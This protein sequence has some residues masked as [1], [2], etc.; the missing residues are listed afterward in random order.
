VTSRDDWQIAFELA[1]TALDLSVSERKIWLANIAPEYTHLRSLLRD[2]LDAETNQSTSQFLETLPKLAGFDDDSLELFVGDAGVA[3]GPYRLIREL[4]AGGMGSVW[5]AARADGSIKREV[6]LKLPHTG[7]H[8]KLLVERFRRE[9]DI[10]A[11]LDHPNIARLYDA[12]VANDDGDGAEGRAGQPYMALEYVDGKPIDRY[13]REANLSVRDKIALFLQVLDAVHFAHSR[14]INHRD[15]KPSNILVTP[16][17]QVR[18]LDF[19][20]A[21]LLAV[22]DGQPNFAQTEFSSR[23]FTPDYASPEQI[24]GLP[25][26]TGSDIYSLGVVLYELLC[27]RAPYKLKRQ[28]RGAL[29][30]AIVESVISRPSTQIRKAASH[31]NVKE[32]NA[33]GTN[34]AKAIN[35]DL[36][37][38]VLKALQKKPEDR[39]ESVAAFAQDLRNHLDNRPVLA[40]APSP[41]YQLRKFIERHKLP[42]ALVVGGV[43]TLVAATTVSVMQAKIASR[44]AK[45]A[46]EIKDFLV[47]TFRNTNPVDARGADFSAR[48]LLDQS[49][50][51]AETRFKNAPAIQ[52]ELFG[53]LSRSYGLLG[54][55]DKARE[56][57]EKALNNMVLAFGPRDPRVQVAKVSLADSALSAFDFA[58]YL[59]LDAEL[60]AICVE[61]LVKQAVESPCWSATYLRARYDY[62]AGLFTQSE[63]RLRDII[64]AA[65]IVKP[66]AYTWAAPYADVYLMLNDLYRGRL[67]SATSLISA[68]AKQHLATVQNAAD[69]VWASDLN[70][71]SRV[72]AAKG[73]LMRARD[74][75]ETGFTL[76]K[77]QFGNAPLWNYSQQR[78]L[79]IAEGS[80]GNVAAA[81]TLFSEAMAGSDKRFGGPNYDSALSR[82]AWGLLLL[83]EGRFVEA[84]KLLTEARTT[85]LAINAVE[86]CWLAR[87]DVAIAA[88][89]GLS[90]AKTDARLALDRLIAAAD[91]RQ[92]IF[93]ARR[94]RYWRAKFSEKPDQPDEASTLLVRLLNEENGA[95]HERSALAIDARLLLAENTIDKNA[96]WPHLEIVATEAARIWGANNRYAERA[97]QRAMNLRPDAKTALRDAY[98]RATKQRQPDELGLIVDAINARTASISK[99]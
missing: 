22:N 61:P 30:D 23:V 85:H 46:N 13:C 44:E 38:I 37:A 47:G 95:P 81:E 16:E 5:L 19:G 25:V 35:A 92:D 29:E 31:N 94:A 43:L 14:L 33:D 96:Q 51:Q 65:Q 89:D 73:E 78:Q 79:G 49:T 48:E 84:K 40:R 24:I 91:A 99:P 39:Y 90:G 17:G 64:A 41:L 28:S 12:G 77:R 87:V 69:P 60:K 76:R 97:L 3:I 52:A 66:G 83:N 53:T 42:S 67:D 18:L 26:G 20:I 34:S 27:G 50:A 71:I 75:A 1:D 57:S 74:A 70:A 58:T 32:H 45:T 56:L 86:N 6:A 54:R 8:R 80:L 2:M 93:T 59:K 36:D 72:L 62:T 21:K 55:E 4:G 63:T 11:A 98:E 68:Q 82:E 88:T 15:I 7:V 10:L 9:L